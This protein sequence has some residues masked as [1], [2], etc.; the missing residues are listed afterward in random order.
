MTQHRLP[1]LVAAAL[2]CALHAAPA[3]AETCASPATNAEP[4]K[5]KKKGFGLGGLLS[6]A[7]QAGAGDLLTTGDLLGSGR[8]AR[9]AGA[10]AGTAAELA[11]TGSQSAAGGVDA[12]TPCNAA[13]AAAPAATSEGARRQPATTDVKYPSRMPP[14]ADFAAIKAAY[15]AFGKVRC[16][17]CEGGYAYDGWASFPRD[18]Y[19]SKYNGSA[20]RL[21]SL[22]V[23]HVHRWKGAESTGTLTIV[24]EDTVN[25]FRC[26]RLSYRLTKGGASA[27]RPGLLCWGYA[28]EYAGSESW[29]EVY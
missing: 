23:G 17:G 6:A 4:T 21:G 19:S 29:N 10:V 11:R 13:S 7:R 22:A 26:R 14:P 5:P 25:G 28:N 15:D 3:S 24:A 9:I 18:D 1:A 8:S 12:S 20:Q 2:L 27:E 16:H